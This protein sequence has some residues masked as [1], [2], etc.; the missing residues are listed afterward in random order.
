MNLL[1]SFQLAQHVNE[2]TQQHGNTLDLVMSTGLNSIRFIYLPKRFKDVC[3]NLSLT[4]NIQI[5]FL[6]YW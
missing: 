6:V 3:D 2:A 5:G 1:G 4:K